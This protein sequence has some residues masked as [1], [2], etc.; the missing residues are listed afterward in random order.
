M[1]NNEKC[2]LLK[3]T[4]Y[5][6]YVNEGRSKSYIS[7]LLNI[8]RETLGNKINHEWDFPLPNKVWHLTPSKE[9][10][11]NENKE[12][13]ISLLNQD[14]SITDVA[15]EL[16]LNYETLHRYIQYDSDVRKAANDNT[17]RMH[18]R[19]RERS[20]CRKESSRLEYIDENTP[21]ENWK[22]ILGY[23][24]YEVSD[25]GRIRSYAMCHKSYYVLKPNINKNINRVYMRL[26]DDE[27][28][29]RNLIVARLVAF[30]FVDGY[31]EERNTVNHKDGNPLNNNASNLEWMSQAEN[32]QHAFSVIGRKASVRRRNYDK[33]IYDGKYE[34]KTNKA[35][36]RFLGI[37]DTQVS[38]YLDAPEKH[39]LQIIPKTNCND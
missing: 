8:N 30:A 32:N 2:E 6:L 36:A 11:L 39:N 28:I 26:T 33:I 16:N 29:S 3:D 23:S 21:G 37:S 24:N 25:K 12:K 17:N 10:F 9:K 38:R 1:N 19:A 7:R 27:G 18:E 20:E 5:Q 15:T 4:I 31:S 14:I 35:L 34:F 13:M 22:P